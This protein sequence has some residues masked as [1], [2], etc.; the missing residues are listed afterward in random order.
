MGRRRGDGKSPGPAKLRR[1]LFD[2]A[3][4]VGGSKDADYDVIPDISRGP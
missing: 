3:M 2:L 1:A 4:R